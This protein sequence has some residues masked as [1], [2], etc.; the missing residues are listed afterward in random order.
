MASASRTGVR[1]VRSGTRPRGVHLLSDSSGNLLDHFMTAIRTQFPEGAFRVE[2]APFLS[3]E[4][5]LREA[6]SKISSGIVLHSLAD[7]QLKAVCMVECARAGLRARDVTGPVVQ[8]LEA[9]S[10]LPA[11]FDP[12]PLHVVDASYLGRMSAIEF[13]MQHDDN[14]RLE[15]LERAQ[16]VLVGVSRVSKSPT[17]LYLAYRG[18]YVANVSVVPAEGLP[19]PLRKHR[20]RNVAA[21]TMAPERLKEIRERRFRDWRLGEQPYSDLRDVAEEVRAAERF[22]AKRRWP[23]IDTTHRAV[24]ETGALVLRALRVRFP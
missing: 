11:A 3:N 17:A 12:K 5:R 13:A 4:A 19:E 8:F 6:L 23:V 9:A 7:P 1:R 21:L 16:V 2:R 10:G 14:R 18:L 24:E 20:R 22:Y 15:H